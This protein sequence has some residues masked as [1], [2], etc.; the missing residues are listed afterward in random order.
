MLHG[1]TGGDNC[2]KRRGDAQLPAGTL[3]DIWPRHL[4]QEPS[5][6][7]QSASPDGTIGQVSP[8]G[9]LLQQGSHSGWMV[10]CMDQE[11]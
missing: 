3:Q 4:G 2:W 1:R 9:C 6:I 5:G 7:P 8:A 11:D 10:R